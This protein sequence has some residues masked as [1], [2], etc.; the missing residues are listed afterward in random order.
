MK[1]T[2]EVLSDIVIND[3]HNKN[4]IKFISIVLSNFFTA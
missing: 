2:K 4:T 1:R 3:E